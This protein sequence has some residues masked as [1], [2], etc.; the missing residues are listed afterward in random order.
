MRLSRPIATIILFFLSFSIAN[1]QRHRDSNI[2]VGGEAKLSNINLKA[3]S[4]WVDSV[5]ATMSDTERLGQLF[6]V[7]AYSGGKDYNEEKIRKLLTERRLGGLIFMQGTPEAQAVQNN[8][9]Q[10][11]ANV[12]LLI[13]M[14]AEWGLGMRLTGAK[15]MPRAMMVGAAHDSVLAY[16]MGVAVAQQLKRL[17]VHINFAPVVDV[18]NNRNNPIINARSFGEDKRWVTRLGLAYMKGMQDNG[19]MACAK[20]FPGHGDTETDS[21]KDLPTI[22]KTMAQLDSLELYPFQ[23]LIN[24]GI[25]SVMVAHMEVPALEPTPGVPTTLSYNTIT[26]VL[27]GRMHFNGLVFT[28]ALN[29]DGIA[30]RFTPGEIDLRAFLAGNDMLLFSQD[31]PTSIR[32]MM[33]AI[34]SG[35]ITRPMLEASVK[36]V[37]GAK[38]DLGLNKWKPVDIFNVTNDV[39][40]NTPAVRRSIAEAAVTLVRDNSGIL[41]KLQNK[42]AQVGYIGVNAGGNTVLSDALLA[43]LPNMKTAWVQKGATDVMTQRALDAMQNTDALIVAVHNLAFYPGSSRNHGLDVQQVSFLQQMQTRPNTIIVM[44]GNAYLMKHFCTA[45]SVMVAYEDDS[46]TQQVVAQILLKQKPARGRL[47]VTPCDYTN[48]PVIAQTTSDVLKPTDFKVDAGV[49]SPAA[50]DKLNMFIQRSIVAGAFP[51]CRIFAAKNGKVF[52]DESFGYYSADKKERVTN[53]TMYDVASVTKILST[54]LAVMRLY[55]QGKL[56]LNSRIGDYLVW[57]KGSD[58]ANL[59]IKDLLLHQAGLKSWIPFYKNTLDASGDLRNDLYAQQPSAKYSYQV[60]KNLYLR[61][62]YPDSIWTEILNSPLENKGKYVY[63]D[64]DYYFLAAV[65]QQL[66]GQSI[67]KY[68]EEQFYKPMNLQRITY[69]PLKKFKE[70]DIAPTEND[71]TFRHQLI[72]G[73]VHDPGAALFGGVAGHAGIFATAQD[74]GAIFQML[75]NGGEYNGKRYFNK[76]TVDYFTAYRAT[77][78]RR[79][80]GFDKPSADA[81][82]GGPAGNRV[83]GYA[84]GHQG[85]TGTCAWADPETGIVFVFLSNRVNPSA[86]N[87]II[88]KQS[89]R[90]VAQDYIYEAY[91]IPVNK[92]RPAVQKKQLAN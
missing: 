72:R 80:L 30:K 27:K 5:Y 55:E 91:G 3:R 49:V 28:D 35:I 33:A 7:A 39:N 12:P 19:V 47:P 87:G 78:S 22:S 53:N 58:K 1:A 20:H 61:N 23:Q 48:T 81:E 79:A 10:Q 84:F 34:D 75:M 83:S 77:I 21:H 16:K 45:P 17:G 52:Y 36:K 64:L 82:D 46:I 88:S 24:H 44:D 69:M 76:T 40:K 14:D 38:Y 90:T 51:G 25:Q 2:Q 59:Q 41:E 15:D 56:K 9:F 32:K 50:L 73:Y 63:S 8:A 11:M 42:N 92:E 62:D 29:M 67:D 18:N 31:V 26:N 65:V 13:G 70:A 4:T 85:F 68:V 86:E 43:E 37:L 60:A 57:T 66:T 6:M 89:I 71:V 74:V 54:T